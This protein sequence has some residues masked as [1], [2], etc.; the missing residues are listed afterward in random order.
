MRISIQRTSRMCHAYQG[1]VWP[2]AGFKG[3]IG[4]D[5]LRVSTPMTSSSM[6]L[7]IEV[8]Q[9]EVVIR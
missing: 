5:L 4:C 9:G 6:H 2:E 7:P 1:A 3:E 8:E